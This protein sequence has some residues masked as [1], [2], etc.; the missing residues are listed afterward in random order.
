MALFPAGSALGLYGLFMLMYVAP[1]L[2]GF[3]DV[4]LTPG[5]LKRYGGGARFALGASVEI[6]FSLL[7]A[8]C[9]T[10]R[11]SLFMAGFSAIQWNPDIKAFYDRLRAKGKHHLSALV[12][13]MRK[14]VILANAVVARDAD[15][16]PTRP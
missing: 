4:A 13:A 3:L 8:P 16:Q 6:V 7:I 2:A 15:W 12:A 9:V 10:L 5:G 11:T 14:L 1:K